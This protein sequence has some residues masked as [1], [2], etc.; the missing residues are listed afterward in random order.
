MS[1]ELQLEEK[2]GQL[3]HIDL[4]ISEIVKS[5]SVLD[6]IND[7]AFNAKAPTETT[8][9][10]PQNLTL[11][12]LNAKLKDLENAESQLNELWIIKNLFKEVELAL[13]TA[14]N[15][16]L[17]CDK[18]DLLSIVKN[19]EKLHKKTTRLSQSNLTIST[20]VKARYD[21]LLNDFGAHLEHV[22]HE[23]VP[24]NTRTEF[25]LKDSLEMTGKSLNFGE[26]ADVVNLY[27]AINPSSKISGQL[28]SLKTDWEKS[29]LEPLIAKRILLRLDSAEKT[30]TLSIRFIDSVPDFS[31]S[32]F[33]RSLQC[34]VHFVNAASLKSLKNHY[35]TKISNGL[36]DIISE[37][38]KNFTEDG[39]SLT[40]ELLHT[41]ELFS[42]TGWTMPLRNIFMGHSDI[43][44]T[45]DGLHLNWITD[46]YID[47]LRNIFA[48]PQ[49]ESDLQYQSL[50]TKTIE[51]QPQV[52]PIPVASQIAPSKQT[53]EQPADNISEELEWD[54]NWG[55]DDEELERA[56]KQSVH[57][58]AWDDNWGE[59]WSDD[60]DHPPKVLPQSTILTG[61]KLE[62]V[63]EMEEAKAHTESYSYAVSAIPEKITGV[64]LE[65]ERETDGADPQILMD[66]IFAL[67]LASYPSV[68]LLFLLLNDLRSV[69][70]QN[71]SL[72]DNAKI[73][74]SHFCQSFS[75]D[76]T[77][78]LQKAGLLDSS[79]ESDDSD[80]EAGFASIAQIKNQ[81]DGLMSSQLQSTNS[82]ELKLFVLQVL[83]LINNIVLQKI[84]RCDEITE[85]QSEEFT[86][87]LEGLQVVEA[88][89]LAKF[90]EEPAV[91]ATTNKIMQTKFLINNHLRSIMEYFYQGELYDFSTDELVS[92]I[93][94]V[95]IPSE[96]RE[97]CL[98][99]IVDVRSS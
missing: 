39:E 28:H 45:L 95:F 22:F 75:N 76:I 13:E 14:F 44:E 46:K 1:L 41:L 26:F 57:S 55:S 35:A 8:N 15:D 89:I 30:H 52:A 7:P 51:I 92:V 33:L 84:L 87:Y 36:A 27:E 32:A 56:T 90:G 40:Q 78:I 77:K 19:I 63:E 5:V 12:Q 54:D 58:D 94:S 72:A 62:A 80:G 2:R 10:E 59:S 60:E 6:V 43:R 18:D 82:H 23:F 3:A 53:T 47:L 96:L 11:Y 48:S 81:L 24:T 74:W 91:L 37:N 97:N 99:E 38:I 34:F 66:F 4:A 61:P 98:N 25:F 68:S 50:V 49:F 67:A 85:Y 16:S 73:E 71:A 64:L 86:R 69:K 31:T 88:E 20:S 21:T 65:F 79:S 29:I 17:D 70:T 9:N 42:S 83:N 93:K